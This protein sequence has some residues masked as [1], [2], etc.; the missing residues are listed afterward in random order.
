ML[1]PVVTYMNFDNN[2]EE[3]SMLVKG[4]SERASIFFIQLVGI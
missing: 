4:D 1:E 2:M 3:D